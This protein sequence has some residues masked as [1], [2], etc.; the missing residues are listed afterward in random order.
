MKKCRV[1]ELIGGSLSDG[2]AETLVK[3]Y[4]AYLDP[5]R[6]ESAVFVDWIVP[7]AAN[8]RI[9]KE[10]REKVFTVYPRYDLFWRGVNKYLRKTFFVHQLKRTI[11][12]FNPDV[13]HVHLSALEYLSKV[14][15][16]LKG[17][18]ILYTCHNTPSMMIEYGSPEDV[19][20]GELVRG[21]SMRLIALHKDMAEELNARYGVRDTVVINNGITLDRFRKQPE[22]KED[23][24]K[25]LGIPLEA[26]VIGN[27]GRFSEEKNHEQIIKVF[28]SVREIKEN[29]FL[30]LIGAGEL[31]SYIE[32]LIESNSLS[33]NTL[34]L[35]NRTDVPRLLKAMDVFLLPSLYE[36]F[37]ISLIEAQAVGLRCVVSDTVTSDSFITGKVTALNLNDPDEKWRDEVLN[38]EGGDGYPDR[39]E[40]FDIKDVIKRV[41][42]LYLGEL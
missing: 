1:L 21:Y 17:R 3:D 5:E 33:Q 32:R 22:G 14:G 34:I 39:L 18:R 36:G 2:G 28:K 19:A 25:S 31:K 29:A 24:R 4:V 11:R 13:I 10:N 16:E 7:K 8:T 35:S 37:P 23:I 12:K 38:L 15:E 30:L 41:E 6:F 26:F 20:V 40:A 42:K 27:I 9:L